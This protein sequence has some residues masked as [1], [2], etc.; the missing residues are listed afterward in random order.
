MYLGGTLRVC[1]SHDGLRKPPVGLLYRSL[2]PDL[3]LAALPLA[4]GDR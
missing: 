3:G 1:S 2:I 4:V